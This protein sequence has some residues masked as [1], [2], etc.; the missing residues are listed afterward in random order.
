[1]AARGDGF[2]PWE[3]AGR[4]RSGLC[5]LDQPKPIGLPHNM[6]TNRIPE[7]THA[8]NYILWL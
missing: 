6:K 4:E 3:C 5:L 7:V 2:D 8:N 1:M